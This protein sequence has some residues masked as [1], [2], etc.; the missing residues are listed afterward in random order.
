MAKSIDLS[1][2]KNLYA[3]AEAFKALAPWQWMYD[4]DIFG[5]QNPETG[6]MGYCCIMG[7]AGEHFAMAV[8]PGEKGLASYFTLLRSSADV[9]IDPDLLF[10]Q[11]CIKVSFEDRDEIDAK[12]RNIMKKLN[13]KFRGRNNWPLFRRFS[14]GYFPWFLSEDEIKFLT[15][16]LQQAVEVTPNFRKKPEML[17]KETTKSVKIF[18]RLA[19]KSNGNISWK[20]AWLEPAFGEQATIKTPPVDQIRLRSIGKN[21]KPS[22]AI[23]EFDIWYFPNPIQE[24]KGDRPYYPVML[25]WADQASG[26]ILR[27]EVATKADFPRQVQ[28]QFYKILEKTNAMPREIWVQKNNAFDILEPLCRETGIKLELYDDLIAMTEIKT[29][30]MNRFF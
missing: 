29:F 20:D 2:W 30:M 21:L 5:V 11:D 6:E 24:K 13:L 4:S 12:D 15:V 9:N 25:G 7:R 10:D 23:W 14:P 8:Y 28:Q 27:H 16:A 17:R 1:L 18:T 19:E 22:D 3:A 26:M